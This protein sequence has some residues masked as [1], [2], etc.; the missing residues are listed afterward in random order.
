MTGQTPDDL[1]Q[2]KQEAL[3]ALQQATTPET[4]EAWRVMYL[5]RKGSVPQL[6]RTI[7]D[8]SPAERKKWGQQGNALRTE[9]TVHYQEKYQIVTTGQSVAPGQTRQS[10]SRTKLTALPTIGHLHPITLTIRSIQAIFSRM[11]FTVV[12]GPE[13]EDP[14]YNF[15][16]LNIPPDHPAREATDTFYTTTGQVL[17]THTSP[18]QLRAVHEHTLT[19]PFK[20]LS[21]GRVFR[22]ERTDA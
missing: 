18:V 21:P 20:I 19:P 10:V 17:R 14:Q 1:E 11:G 3:T 4:L 8:V 7:K 16:L 15:D 12:E 22:A 5:G 2:L 6:L 13:V 9:L